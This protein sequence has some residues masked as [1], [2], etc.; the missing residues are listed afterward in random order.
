MKQVQV[1]LN[2]VNMLGVIALGGFSIDRGVL[3]LMPAPPGED[4]FIELF[5]RVH[6]MRCDMTFRSVDTL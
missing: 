6:Q 3:P 4:P 5:L 1:I 2:G